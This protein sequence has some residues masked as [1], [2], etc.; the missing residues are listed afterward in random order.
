MKN[1][2]ILN[3]ISGGRE[4]ATDLVMEVSLDV[5]FTLSREDC[6]KFCSMPI[7]FCP[8]DVSN[9]EHHKN[10]PVAF[11]IQGDLFDGQSVYLAGVICDYDL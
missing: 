1:L 9:I 5:P 10:V 6:D 2:E 7:G 3:A 8:V 4:A 11:I